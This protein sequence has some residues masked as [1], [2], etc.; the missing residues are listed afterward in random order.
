MAEDSDSLDSEC[1]PQFTV[2]QMTAL[3][4]LMMRDLL[5]VGTLRDH[6]TRHFARPTYIEEPDLRHLIWQPGEA[7][8]ILIETNHRWRPELTEARP[9][10]IIKRNDFENQRIG[11]FGEALQGPDKYGD[12]HYNTFWVGSLTL[13]CMGGSGEQAELLGTEVQ[14]DLTEFGPVIAKSLGL[15]R[16]QVVRRG[17][18]GKLREAKDIWATPVVLAVAFDERWIIIQNAPKLRIAFTRLTG[19]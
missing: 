12:V 18:V 17:A 9:A 1:S 8:N 2:P 11:A 16:W 7:T 4:S 10:V 13:F 3:C 19:C 14:R 15:K 5:L 6:L